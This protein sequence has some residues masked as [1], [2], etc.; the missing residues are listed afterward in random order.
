MRGLLPPPQTRGRDQLTLQTKATSRDAS[1]ADLDSPGPS[2]R[3]LRL[4]GEA[5]AAAAPG[6]K[7]VERHQSGGSTI[8]VETIQTDRIWEPGGRSW[9]CRC[10][11]RRCT[12]EPLQPIS[13]RGSSGRQSHVLSVAP[14]LT[15]VSTSSYIH[16]LMSSSG[17]E[18]DLMALMKFSFD[19]NTPKTRLERTGRTQRPLVEA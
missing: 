8:A 19:K 14:P 11:A 10:T 16:S 15:S 3:S 7:A 5:G 9:C 18:N 1:P 13:N 17:P 2:A 4:S 12:V 6:E